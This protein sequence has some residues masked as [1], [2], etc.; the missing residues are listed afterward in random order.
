[1]KALFT[2]SFVRTLIIAVVSAL[3]VV[4]GIYAYET[5]WSGKAAIT[6]RPP[7]GEAQLEMT[8]V[9]VTDTYG[10]WDEDNGTWTVSLLRGIWAGLLISLRNTG[11]DLVEIQKCVNGSC[12]DTARSV[13]LAPG[14]TVTVSG[15]SSI[16]A[17]E[18]GSVVFEVHADVNAEPG[19]LPDVQLEVT[20]SEDTRRGIRWPR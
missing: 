15:Y 5:L 9:T 2:R 16:A 1:M 14:V 12:F 20:L 8:G 11:G 10:T 18:T 7:S 4:G 13:E 19:A 6:I 17:G 3:I